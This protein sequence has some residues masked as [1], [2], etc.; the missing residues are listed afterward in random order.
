M[1]LLL[2]GTQVPNIQGKCILYFSLQHVLCSVQA[3]MPRL[4][5]MMIRWFIRGTNWNRLKYIRVK[6]VCAAS[7][8][9]LKYKCENS[10]RCSAGRPGNP[11]ASSHEQAL[12]RRS[13]PG[14]TDLVSASG[15]QRLQPHSALLL[16]A[17]GQAVGCTLW[18]LPS[19]FKQTA[20]MRCALDLCVVFCVLFV[21]CF[22]FFFFLSA[23]LPSIF[24]VQFSFY[25]CS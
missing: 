15:L 21:L 18:V 25:S 10:F 22:F 8:H 11:H 7:Q 6:E 23:F 4:W 13:M 20:H 9:S 17:V 12:S 1:Y 5:L 24:S 3:N 2:Q 14:G 16:Q 19:A